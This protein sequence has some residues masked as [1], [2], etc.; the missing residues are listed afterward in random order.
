MKTKPFAILLLLIF[1]ILLF[2]SCDYIENTFGNGMPDE[3]QN[4]HTHDYSVRS[5]AAIYQK[6]QA[7]CTEASVYYF[8]CTC[9][10]KGSETFRDG[11]ALGHVWMRENCENPLYCA[12]C[13]IKDD[14]PAGHIWQT[15]DDGKIK[16]CTSCGTVLNLD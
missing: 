16:T 2:A 9:G 5:T 13:H 14:K 4:I 8:S 15:S 3:E 10:E 11:E 1:S 6:S 12:V 7:T